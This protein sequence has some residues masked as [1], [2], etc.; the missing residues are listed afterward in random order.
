MNLF[1][2]VKVDTDKCT[3]CH[4]C[5]TAC[6]VKFCNDGSNDYVTI[7][8]DLC[9][10]CGNCIEAC[11]HEAR[12]GVDDF[13]RF[14]SDIN[15]YKFT[16]I[17]A[18][19]VAANFPGNYLKINGW[20]K[21]LGIEAIF[22]VSFGAELTVKSYLDYAQ[23]KSPKTI[24]AQPCPA[25][26]TFC[27]IY[28]PELLKYL[29]PADS[30]MLHTIKMIETFYKKRFSE[31]KIA[32]VS[33]CFAKKREFD[34]TGYSEKVYNITYKS[35]SKY[36]QENKIDITEFEEVDFY[37]PPA[38][39]AVLFSTP[40]GLMQ[41]A[42]RDMP[43][44]ISS[45]RKIE[46]VHTIYKY[47][48][49]FNNSVN[50]GTNPFLIDCLNCEMGCNG[51]PGTLNQKKGVDEI[52]YLINQRNIE[53]QKK[54]K[55]KKIS[56]TSKKVNKI[57]N[58]YWKP[59]LYNRSYKDLSGNNTIKEPNETELKQV[60]ES[61]HK[62]SDDDI[63][64][65]T[66]CGYGNCHAMAVAIFN[67]LNKPENCHYYK[68]KMIEIEHQKAEEGQKQAMSALIK[69]DQSQK[70]LKKEHDKKLRLAEAISSTTTELEANNDSIAKMANNL[71]DLSSSQQI[72]L[73]ELVNGIEDAYKITTELRPIVNSITEIAE[74]TDLLALNAAIE[75]ARAGEVG[76][77]FAVVSEEVK[78][79]AEITQKEV[80]K[81]EPFAKKIKFSFD[82]INQVSKDVFQQFED[83][84]NLTSEVTTSTEEMAAATI[85]LNREVESL[86]KT[87]SLD[88]L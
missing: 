59:N 77:G 58:K 47:L 27:E 57:I 46:G 52:E 35:I 33:P 13:D 38:E 63:Y 75:A 74:Q 40:G 5:I 25:I 4:A 72:S 12:Y 16:A 80:K 64:N 28:H 81:I 61:M 7:N 23:K 24:V 65:C 87:E 32:V 17:A 2:V 76:R 49:E 82:E 54:Y 78:N 70:K 26:V 9:I 66:A 84:A 21:S 48:S 20:L 62:H 36:L 30:P 3:N 15:K 50:N 51:G 45:T 6:P 19:A 44:L 11:T 60:Y 86:L 71:F 53:V 43:G 10:G 22:D 1:P 88:D 73:K 68:H 18:P 42:E 83:I 34:E 79:L 69:I 8:Q 56:K 67:G 31:H 29:A 39:R 85:D 37:N 41:T 55:S 14:I